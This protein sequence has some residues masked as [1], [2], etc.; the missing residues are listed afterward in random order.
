MS[1]HSFLD[2]CS[3]SCTPCTLSGALVLGNHGVCIRRVMGQHC[4]FY[5]FHTVLCKVLWTAGYL[6]Q[7]F[8]LHSCRR[9]RTTF[10]FCAWDTW[11]VNKLLIVICIT[12]N[13]QWRQEQQLISSWNTGFKLW[14]GTS[15][16]L[17]DADM[18]FLTERYI[19]NL[20]LQWAYIQ[21]VPPRTSHKELVENIHA[22]W[23]QLQG[24]KVMVLEIGHV[25][26]C[27]RAIPVK[28]SPMQVRWA[29]DDQDLTI[30]MFVCIPMPLEFSCR[31]VK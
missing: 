18:V 2:K 17:R 29:I 19:P 10:A 9:G 22:S 11:W 30:I 31:G 24:C 27:N 13:F 14:V 12:F 28:D 25:D 26:V 5:Q 1:Y 7:P 16:I 23:I 6:E 3:A 4:I 20:T 8:S 21:L 15:L